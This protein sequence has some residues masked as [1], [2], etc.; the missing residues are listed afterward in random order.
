[1]TRPPNS[2]NEQEPSNRRRL[3][4]ILLRRTSLVLGIILLA[5]IAG[6]AWW[7]RK[8]IYTD[9]APLVER[10]LEQSLGRPVDLGQVTSFSLNSLTFDSL[11]IPATP[12][13]SDRVKVEDVQVE[14][15][16]LQV[17]L[18]RSLPI[19]VTLIQPDV[20]IQQNQQGEWVTTQIK[21]TPQ[22][23]GP[24][25]INLQTIRIR[26]G[27]VVLDPTPR[28]GRPNG[29]VALD[30][31][32][33]VAQLLPEN[34]GISYDITGQLTRGGTVNIVGQTRPS[35]E[36]THLQVNAQNVQAADL[37]RLVEL[38]IRLQAGQVDGNLTVELQPTQP[39]VSLT[40]TANVRQVTA[41]V[42]NLPQKF[43]NATGT[44]TFQGQQVAFENLN[45]NYG[46][47]PLQVSGGLSTQ[48]G[49]N[50]SGQVKPVSAKN[51]IDTLNVTSPVPI[52]G[53]VQANIQLQGPINEPVL[54]GTLSTIKAA[55]VDRVQFQNISTGFRLNVGKGTSQ[56]TLSNLQL[57]PVA[58]GQ[59]AGKGEVKLG[60]Q[61]DVMLNL[62]AEDVPADVLAKTYG[63]SSPITIGTVSANAEVTGTVEGKQPLQLILSNVQATPPAGGQITAGG[64]IGLSP[65]GNV[66]LNVQAQGLPANAIAKSY[67]LSLPFN[68]GGVS[69]NATVTGSVGTQKPLQVNI[70][71][72]RATPEIGGEIVA[73]GQ[74]GLAPQGNVSLN[75]Q[76]ENLPGDA[77]AKAYN[78]SPPVTIGNVS[79]NAKITGNIGDLRTVAQVKAPQATYP[80]TGQVVVAQQDGGI[81]FRDTV[82]RVAGGTLTARGQVEQDRWR[83]FV[84]A[85]GLQLSRFEQVPP[86]FQGILSSELNL[87]G[88]TNSFQPSAIQATGQATLRNIAGGRVDVNNINLN[89]GQWQAVAK[90]SQVELNRFSEQLRGQLNTNLRV[91]GTT[92][93]FQLNNIRAAGQVRLSQGIA[94]ID[95]PLTAQIQWNGDRIIVERA[96]APGLIA[97]GTIDVQLPETGTP[98]IA[99]LNLDVRAENFSLQEFDN[100]PQNVAL[101][102]QAD[103]NGQITG[104]PDAPNAAGNLRLEN[105]SVSGLNFDQV[106]TGKV[107]FQPGQG[108]ELRLS[109]PQDQIA[110][111]LGPE[112][113]PTSFVIRRN[114]AV[115]TGRTEGDTLFVNVEDFPVAVL[116]NAV[117]GDRLNLQPLAGD[118]SADL[119]VNLKEYTVAGNVTVDQP[120]VGR[121]TADQFQGNIS[122]ANGTATLTGGDLQIGDD[123]ISIN[124]NVETA[125]QTPQF[126][127]QVSFDQARIQNIL[128]AFNVFDF[129]D[130]SGG[131]TTPE[132]AGASALETVSVGLPNANLLSQI[133]RFSEIEALLTQEQTQR[134]EAQTLP[135]LAELQGVLSGQ[136]QA[137]G[138]LPTGINADFNIQSSK[139]A[140][141]QYNVDGLIAQ[142]SFNNGVVT[143]SPL[144]I[145]LAKQGL[146]AF[147]G[148]LGSDALSGQVR[149]SSLP[150]SLLEPFLQDF[151]VDVTGEVTALAT[152]AGSL[153]NPRAIGEVTLA[154]A[155]INEEPVKT[156]DL[157]FN[158][159]DGR[160]NF[161]SNILI[162]G[163]E[164]V[165]IQGS[166]PVPLPFAVVQPESNEIS[167]AANVQNEGLGLLNLFTDQVT[168]VQGQGLV[169]VEVQ[170]TLD[171]PTITGNVTVQDATFRAAALPEPLTGVT[172]TLEFNGNRVN[173]Q[174][175]QGQYN[176]GEVTAAGI[177][178]IFASQQALTEAATNP[179]TVSIDNLDLEVAGLYQGGV[180]GNVVITGTALEPAIGGKIILSDGQVLIGGQETAAVATPAAGT[181]NESATPGAP[182]TTNRPPIEFENLQLVLDDDV[183]ITNR[184]LVAFIPTEFAPP[185]ISFKAKGDLTINGSLANPRP[186]GVVRLT[187]GQ[188]NLF[189]TQ[190]TLERGYEQTATFTPTGGID[191]VLDVRLVAL[192]PEGSG[193]RLPTSPF[194]SEISDAP[195]F[196][197]LGTLETIRVEARATG[198]ASEL[199][200]NLTLTSDPQRSESE[201]IS[202]LG[203]SIINTLGQA[204]P[205]LGIASFAGAGI[206]S[207]LQGSLSQIAQSIGFSEF[208]IYP[209]TVANE[210]T[211]AS[212]LSLAAEGVFDVTGNLSASISRVFLTNESFRY[213]V[214]YRLNDNIRVRGTTDFGDESRLTVNYESRF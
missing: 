177:I 9:L 100:L 124:A 84:D 180:S 127:A 165:E 3:W 154:N 133:R 171:Q 49:F 102:G 95:D 21:T 52:S 6:G 173:V 57:T 186:Q 14:F 5:G 206:L 160:L 117:P 188:V 7:L 110:V 136:I 62:R 35:T 44:L 80:V 168:F 104:T 61:T 75:V 137:S 32:G 114:Q 43:N 140:W 23:Q 185:I 19:N 208:R 157:S 149:V 83:A 207:D 129:Q 151:P 201:I 30:N 81:R 197:S 39:E 146:I 69:A 167:I 76:A 26:N 36:Q 162:T 12:T 183:R 41:Q 181:P 118:I 189:A 211:R 179:L 132:F 159:N 113:L 196:T 90:V 139:L 142:G 119:A 89:N 64:Q 86:Q 18:T 8:F 158:F 55:Q 203:G 130:L 47:I 191:P 88:T 50:V 145:D 125:G 210:A 148:Q 56:L 143:L 170:G 176:Q 178:P 67:N 16:P 99:A 213:G 22:G 214:L 190:F 166:V 193:T 202:L 120:R 103:F 115:A 126:Q 184:S 72:I 74:V 97:Q 71:S 107:N 204:D 63:F 98:Q 152:L 42:E 40:G 144:R 11:S 182:T 1:M 54:S 65:Q 112:N 2:E 194:S 93:S 108:T 175:V 27:D 200:Q 96:T 45:A 212:V 153:E 4:L 66:A 92:E 164:P 15:S 131:L 53:Q 111:N 138:S 169:D 85:E 33:G 29:P 174:N 13:D 192:V 20:Y 205:A 128:Q 46:K 109:G 68:V 70:S 105:F 209:T 135:T 199:E 37:S 77:I 161:A 101:A 123:N 163:T 94:V 31:V 48:T 141:G 87:A 172:G 147:T 60:R 28:P 58:G 79:A 122:F 10:N 91:A 34:Q 82:V 51:A 134:E 156:G 25:Q 78:T 116:E 17:L 59:I 106:L 187:Q 150:L 73:T 38:P 121:L 24:I 195:T 155:V 198:P